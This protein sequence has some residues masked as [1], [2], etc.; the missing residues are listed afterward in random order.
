MALPINNISH[1][2]PQKKPFV[3]VDTLVD[4]TA[5]K[6]T[7]SFTI[8]DNNLFVENATFLESGL[9]E[10]M[11]QT[12]ALHTGYNYFLK[13]EEAPIGYIGSIKKVAILKLPILNETITTE[14]TI[15]HEFM[16]VTMVEVKAF[17]QNKEEIASA[18]MKTVIAS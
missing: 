10:N 4:F 5:E 11:A 16:G 17:N 3:M 7:S 8:L 18:E 14:A 6:V 13:N 15:L 2:I 12:V 9:I 1:L